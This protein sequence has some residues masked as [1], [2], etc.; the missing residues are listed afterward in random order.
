M[1][2][3][4]SFDSAR[5]TDEQKAQ[6]IVKRLSAFSELPLNLNGSGVLRTEDPRQINLPP[7]VVVSTLLNDW[8]NRESYEDFYGLRQAKAFKAV[9]PPEILA[10]CRANTGQILMRPTHQRG[11]QIKQRDA[12]SLITQSI[13]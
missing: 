11:G 13:R 3:L 10:G 12:I 4:Q 9:V 1:R 7:G 6:V 5:C 8:A 2:P